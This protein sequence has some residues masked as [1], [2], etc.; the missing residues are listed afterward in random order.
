MPLAGL[1][2]GLS[3][4]LLLEKLGRR[5]TFWLSP[6]PFMLGALLAALAI[7]VNMIYIGRA[8]TGFFVGVI[9]PTIPVYL[10]ETLHPEVRGTLGVLPATLGNTGLLL[11]YVLGMWFGYFGLS[12]AG[13]VSNASKLMLIKLSINMKTS[14]GRSELRSGYLA[15]PPIN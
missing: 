8:I 5:M 3:A 6:I 2:G 1:A 4:G 13:A 10:S 9:S 7:D 12:I 11:V 15:P 14:L